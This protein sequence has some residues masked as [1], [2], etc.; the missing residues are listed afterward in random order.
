MKRLRERFPAKPR[1]AEVRVELGLDST[2][3]EVA[4][5]L[6]VLADPVAKRDFSWNRLSVI[7]REIRSALTEKGIA[8]WPHVSFRTESEQRVIDVAPTL[9]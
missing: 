6:V 7:D 1:V 3:D 9:V 2:G 4:L 8:A 5:V